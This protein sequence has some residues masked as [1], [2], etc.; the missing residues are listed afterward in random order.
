[1][2][3]KPGFSKKTVSKNI[4]TLMKEGRSQSQ[5]T[6]IALSEASKARRKASQKKK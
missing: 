2:P 3:L 4:E 5:A 6:A 1:M